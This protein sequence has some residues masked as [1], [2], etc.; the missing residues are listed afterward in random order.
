MRTTAIPAKHDRRCPL[1]IRPK[2]LLCGLLAVLMLIGVFSVS[3]DAA[4]QTDLVYLFIN[5]TLIQSLTS[6]NMPLRV[7][8]SMYISYRYLTRIKPIKYF[9]DEDI[10]ILKVYT[11]NGSLFFDIG[12][13]IT[14]DQDGR[15]Y[16]YLAEIRNRREQ[17]LMPLENISM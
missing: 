9:Y 8:N 14:Y 2:R 12:N 4:A 6:S 15:I 7:N 17:Y 5:D 11:S 13:S 10:R 3:L 16:S 1:T